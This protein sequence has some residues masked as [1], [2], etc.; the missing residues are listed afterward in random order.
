MIASDT[1]VK[2]T[3]DNKLKC[4]LMMPLFFYIEVKYEALRK[5]VEV[6][7][8]KFVFNLTIDSLA[9]LMHI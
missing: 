5:S 9:I 1:F 8:A 6:Q 4:R 7:I 2:K 3:S